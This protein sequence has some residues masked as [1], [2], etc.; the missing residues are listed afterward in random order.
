MLAPAQTF[1]PCSLTE[2][3]ALWGLRPV[4]PVGC[5]CGLDSGGGIVAAA[6]EPPP[7]PQ[8][9]PTRKHQK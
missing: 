3:A 1:A 9:E 4:R 8:K 5:I 7:M 6:P 2:G